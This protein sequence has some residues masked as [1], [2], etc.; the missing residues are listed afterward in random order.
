MVGG[1]ALPGCRP[2][3]ASSRAQR[4]RELSGLSCEGTDGIHEGAEPMA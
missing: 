2:L 4:V 1:V 3:T